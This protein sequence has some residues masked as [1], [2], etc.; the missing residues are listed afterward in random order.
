[1]PS[2][3]LHPRFESVLVTPEVRS[4]K[5]E[6][7]PFDKFVEEA[8]FEAL[9]ELP[10]TEAWERALPKEDSAGADGFLKLLGLDNPLAVDITVSSNPKEIKEKLSRIGEKYP[11]KIEREDALIQGSPFTPIK[12]LAL[13][14]SKK[15]FINCYNQYVSQGG[16]SIELPLDIKTA[17][18]KELINAIR[19]FYDAIFPGNPALAKRKFDELISNWLDVTSR[20]Q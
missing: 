1:M 10:F 3:E 19:K 7:L 11:A 5:R 14:F 9:S 16:N 15:D 17:V 20:A 6:L 4:E 18:F 8:A 13:F 12:Y 2:P